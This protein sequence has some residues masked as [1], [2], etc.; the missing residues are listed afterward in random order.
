MALAINTNH[1][2]SS[3]QAFLACTRA[4]V[5]TLALPLLMNLS[6][7]G[8]SPADT[9]ITPETQTQ[10]HSP[11][12]EAATL[13]N[14]DSF[15]NN[16]LAN[17]WSPELMTPTAGLITKEQTR[18]GKQAMRFSWKPTQADGTNKML[19]S[20]LATASPANGETER[21]YGYSSFMPSANMANDDQ[22]TIV[23]QWHGVADPG[24]SDSV[25]PLRFEVKSDQ[26]QLVYVASSKPIVK[27]LQH[28]TS[29]KEIALGTVSY[30]RWVDYVVHV[31]WD[32]NGKTGLL[33]VWQDGVLKV[34]DQNINIGY[35]QIQ[36]P[37]W[38]VGLYCWTGKSRAAEKVIYCDEV[39]IGNATAGYDAVKP[40]R[41]NN[42]AR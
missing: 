29:Q 31:K 6:L 27:L 13:I 37:Y 4:A 22:I 39:R 28:P 20:E 24:F 19:H 14:N 16:K 15:E 18:A 32:A 35:P 36:K 5:L 11:A 9:T 17:F 42:T 38:K 10:T 23:S 41:A 3:T 12:R 40:G 8:C 26:L 25:P 30:D 33:Q 2:Q 34:D 1:K 7:T 21:W